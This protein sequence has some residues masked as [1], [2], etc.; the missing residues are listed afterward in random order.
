MTCLVRAAT[1]ITGVQLLAMDALNLLQLVLATDNELDLLQ[2]LVDSAENRNNIPVRVI[3]I[4][5]AADLANQ[6]EHTRCIANIEKLQSK[7]GHLCI[8]V[9]RFTE[10]ITNQRVADVRLCADQTINS[11]QITCRLKP[12]PAG[13][14]FDYDL[15]ESEDSSDFIDSDLYIGEIATYT[16][17]PYIPGLENS[18]N[19]ANSASSEDDLYS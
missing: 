15:G 3:I 7:F 16:Y 17:E 18:E 2:L 13:H 12:L 14:S 1:A 8:V 9:L 5:A 10:P 4:A 11:A 6:D 19:R